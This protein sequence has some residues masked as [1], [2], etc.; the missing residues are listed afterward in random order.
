MLIVHYPVGKD[1]IIDSK[2]SLSAYTDYMNAE[3]DEDRKNALVRHNRSVRSHVDELVR[4][5]Y[6]SYRGNGSMRRLISSS[7]S[8]RMRRRISLP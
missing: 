5:N 2:V 4:K 7:C 1:V 3:S 8:F 6:S